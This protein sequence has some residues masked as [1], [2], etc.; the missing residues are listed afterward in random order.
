M[1]KRR[2]SKRRNETGT[3]DLDGYTKTIQWEMQTDG[4]LPTVKVLNAEEGLL[5]ITAT[6][7]VKPGIY[8]LA[9]EHP[10]HI[11]IILKVEVL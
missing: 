7:K 6:K 1:D 4:V 2:K 9:L 5:S 3:V 10:D 11:P 8:E